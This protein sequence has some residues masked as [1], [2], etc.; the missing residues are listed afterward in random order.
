MKK[1]CLIASSGGH[2]EQIMMLRPLIEKYDGFVVTEKTT[3][4]L[5]IG[6]AKLY[7]LKQI[8]RHE[9]K[10]PYYMFINFIKSFSIFLKEKPDVIIS[11]GALATIPMCVLGKILKRKIVFIES[12]AKTNSPTLSGKLVYKFAD[13]FIIQW[14]SMKDFYPNATFL[15]SIY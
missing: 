2:F 12:F 3:Y 1:V 11:T 6:F 5:S 14:E 10:F 15:G 9:F 13:V 7:H 8:N 4:D